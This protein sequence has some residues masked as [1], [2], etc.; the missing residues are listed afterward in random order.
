MQESNTTF[1]VRIPRDHYTGSFPLVLEVSAQ[2][3]NIRIQ[4]EV[5][6]L[7]PDPLLLKSAKQPEG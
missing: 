2:P 1:V 3:G 6:F 7:G 5:E 4:R